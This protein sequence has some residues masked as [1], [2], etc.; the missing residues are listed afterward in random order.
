MSLFIMG[1]YNGA[2]VC[3]LVEKNLHCE[4]SRLCDQKHRGL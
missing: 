2:E 3:E 4:L 1:A